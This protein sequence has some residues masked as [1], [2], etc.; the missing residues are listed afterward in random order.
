MSK[1]NKNNMK[2]KSEYEITKTRYEA[3]REKIK[4][5]LDSECPECG[6]TDI[7]NGMITDGEYNYYTC[8]ECGTEWKVLREDYKNRRSCLQEE[9]LLE[10]AP[11]A[12]AIVLTIIL[13]IAPTFIFT[14]L[15]LK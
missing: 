7:W 1:F 9:F 4:E 3:E 12:F 15:S 8:K 2:G 13:V 5:K 11:S 10:F 6:Y 14:I